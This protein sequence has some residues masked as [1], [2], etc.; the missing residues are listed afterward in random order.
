MLAVSLYGKNGVDWNDAV[1]GSTATCYLVQG[2]AGVAEFPEIIMKVFGKQELNNEGIYFLDLFIRGKPWTVVVD[3]IFLFKSASSGFDKYIL[4]A[5]RL[6]DDRSLWG[7]LVEKAW[8][9]I[10][11]NYEVA[12][13]GLMKNGFRVL[14]GAPTFGYSLRLKSSA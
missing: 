10:V 12:D 6:G 14:S 7:P 1:Q 2:M 8:A 9:K 5:A 3:D 11:G 4:K 13:Y